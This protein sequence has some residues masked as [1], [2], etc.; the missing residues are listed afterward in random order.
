MHNPIWSY[1]LPDFIN[2]QNFS[3]SHKRVLKTIHFPKEDTQTF[4]SPLR[5]QNIHI[6]LQGN[7]LLQKNSPYQRKIHTPFHQE[8]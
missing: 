2:S 1:A 5:S 6:Y 7:S 4:N 3:S 8:R